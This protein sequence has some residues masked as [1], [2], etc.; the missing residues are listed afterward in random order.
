MKNESSCF[1]DNKIELKEGIRQLVLS[2]NPLI[3]GTGVFNDYASLE[4]GRYTL[5]R[6]HGRIDRAIFGRSFKYV[7][8]K[9]RTFFFAFPERITFNLHYH[10]YI[11][12]PLGKLERFME[13]APNI[14]KE[15][16]P[17]GNL[18]LDPIISETELRKGSYYI[19]K[20]CFM[21]R[22]FENFIISSEFCF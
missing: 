2:T 16:C 11:R 19:T 17:S 14:W 4:R 7:P 6:A 8:M 22:N 15:I 3:F 9:D 20:D 18:A 21:E 1:A 12:P 10:L 13:V 5:K